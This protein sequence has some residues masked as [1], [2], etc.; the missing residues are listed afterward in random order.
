MRHFFLLYFLVAHESSKYFL[1]FCRFVSFMSNQIFDWL[2]TFWL[3]KNLIWICFGKIKFHIFMRFRFVQD[4]FANLFMKINHM[5]FWRFDRI[6]NQK[7][8]LKFCCYLRNR[9]PLWRHRPSITKHDMFCYYWVFACFYNTI[10]MG[11]IS[12][13]VEYT[14]EL[15]YYFIIHI[16][17]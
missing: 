3:Q 16:L 9:S 5:C 7:P 8:Y 10:F 4:L 13:L 12:K 14:I 11:Y 2:C 1:C 15:Y 6:S 17:L